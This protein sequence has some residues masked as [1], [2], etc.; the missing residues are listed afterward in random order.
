MKPR[1]YKTWAVARKDQEF[2]DANVFFTPSGTKDAAKRLLR[3]DL[4][5]NNEEFEV[6]LVRV[7][8][9]RGKQ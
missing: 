3:W 7:S 2:N 8:E 1:E 4:F 9:L 5:D 6:V